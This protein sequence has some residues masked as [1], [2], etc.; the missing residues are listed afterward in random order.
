MTTIAAEAQPNT[1]SPAPRIM[2]LYQLFMLA[3]CV[4]AL[5]ASSSRT[6]F[7]KIRRSRRSSTLRISSSAS[8]SRS[9][10]FLVPE[11]EA[12]DAEIAGLRDEIQRLT[13]AVE[14]LTQRA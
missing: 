11:D 9:A 8:H 2:P 13:E 4:L 12:T 6:L 5:P 3:L 10:W 7:G 1:P 14:K